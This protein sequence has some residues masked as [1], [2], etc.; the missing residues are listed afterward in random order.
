MPYVPLQT[1]CLLEQHDDLKALFKG[2][3]VPDPKRTVYVVDHVTA[4]WRMKS[5][6]GVLL[7][8]VRV[9]FKFIPKLL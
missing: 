3:A 7:E 4:K 8:T 1:H 6:T 5:K 9:Q 2:Y